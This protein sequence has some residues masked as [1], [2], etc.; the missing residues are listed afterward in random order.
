MDLELLMVRVSP[1]YTKFLKAEPMSPI[2]DSNRH[3]EPGAVNQFVPVEAAMI[4]DVFITGKDAV[5]E[6]VVAHILPNVFNGIELGRLGWEG[7]ERHVFRHLQLRG[8]VPPSLV[9]EHNGV[10][11]GFYSQRDL[12]QMQFHGLGV[13]KWQDKAGRLAERG[14]DGAEDVSGGG[15]LIF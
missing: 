5:G 13:A 15:S 9:H 10:G 14:A 1:A 8:Y 6:P 3:D 11:A 7:D 4:D 2:A 12:L